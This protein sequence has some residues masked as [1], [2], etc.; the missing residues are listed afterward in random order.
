M[1][2]HRHLIDRG[3]GGFRFYSYVKE[4]LGALRVGT[5]FE[6]DERGRNGERFGCLDQLPWSFHGF[7]RS[8]YFCEFDDYASRRLSVA[9]AAAEYERKNLR[10]FEALR[11]APEQ[12]Y[13][14]WY[15]GLLSICREDGL[16]WIGGSPYL[17]PSSTISTAIVAEAIMKNDELV[18]KLN[19]V[20]KAAFVEHYSLFKSYAEGSISRQRCIDLLVANGASNPEGAAIRASNAVL[21]FR[22]GMDQ[23]ALS[24]ISV[25]SKVP[26]N[27]VRAASEL[28]L[29][30]K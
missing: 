27:I 4:G 11:A 2:V 6:M 18:R 5:Y 23:E 22:A 7:E 14:D 10:F 1:F 16:P 8:D 15:D 17:I 29:A 25:S 21:I 3:Y 19:S 9:Q 24:L 12:S 13:I 20:G 30:G 26:S 28:V